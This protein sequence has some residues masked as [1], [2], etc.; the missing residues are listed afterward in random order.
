MDTD[1]GVPSSQGSVIIYVPVMVPVTPESMQVTPIITAAAMDCEEEESHQQSQ[2]QRP[3]PP[4]TLE[5]EATSRHRLRVREEI[6]IGDNWRFRE[7]EAEKEERASWRMTTEPQPTEPSQQG[8]ESYH[9]AREEADVMALD[10]IPT[11]AITASPELPQL[12]PCMQLQP[13]QQPFHN[14]QSEQQCR[15]LQPYQQHFHNEQPDQHHPGIEW[16]SSQLQNYSPNNVST[17]HTTS[18]PAGDD[19]EERDD[20]DEEVITEEV[21]ETTYRERVSDGTMEHERSFTVVERRTVSTSRTN[22]MDVDSEEEEPTNQPFVEEVDDE[23]PTVQRLEAPHA[24]ELLIWRPE[25]DE[26]RE[27]ATGEVRELTWLEP[28][29]EEAQEQPRRFRWLPE[30]VISTTPAPLPTPPPT[31]PTGPYVFQALA[32][33]PRTMRCGMESAERILKKTGHRFYPETIVDACR[34]TAERLHAYNP[35]VHYT[36]ESSDQ[37]Y[38]TE[39][40]VEVYVSVL[41]EKGRAVHVHT[42]DEIDRNPPDAVLLQDDSHYWA[43][44]RPN[45]SPGDTAPRPWHAYEHWMERPQL[46]RRLKDYVTEALRAGTTVVAFYG[47]QLSDRGQKRGRAEWSITGGERQAKRTVGED[48]QPQIREYHPQIFQANDEFTV[49]ASSSTVHDQRAPQNRFDL[50]VDYRMNLEPT[51]SLWVQWNVK[52]RKSH[53]PHMTEHWRRYLYDNVSDRQRAW[54]RNILQYPPETQQREQPRGPDA[55]PGGDGAPQS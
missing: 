54:M 51:P 44:A 36:M 18:Y 1:E 24:T 43:V 4:I 50:S 49:G 21:R 35:T 40:T 11:P 15:Q 45:P 16:H 33:P 3:T 13:Y 10:N 2:Q 46:V 28:P 42:P 25:S 47:W 38:P 7:A 31:Q 39:Y 53:W 23:T 22:P 27:T 8:Q 20:R 48:G 32:L 52:R 6:V 30:V 29:Q 12:Q 17:H 14:E 19:A 41:N 9:P 55:Q 34:R 26:A 5:A 37:R